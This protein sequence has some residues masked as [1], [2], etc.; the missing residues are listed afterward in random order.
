[1]PKDIKDISASIMGEIRHG[2]VKM[3]P[4]LYFVLGSI[5]VLAGLVASAL[6]SIFLFALIRFSLRSHGPMGE[7]R[8]DQLVAAFPWWALILGVLGLLVGLWL[9]R[10]YDFSYKFNFKILIIVFVAA[11][12]IAGYLVD[13]AGLNT[14]F[15]HQGCMNRFYGGTN[16]PGLHR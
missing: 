10:K 7:Y 8:W 3:K 12:V 2:E 14:Y 13:A 15:S 1:M 11:I 5:L 9:I 16:C 6:T 4:K